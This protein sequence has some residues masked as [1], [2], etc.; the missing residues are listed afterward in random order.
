MNV[1]AD[2]LVGCKLEPIEETAAADAAYERAMPSLRD[3]FEEHMAV[4]PNRSKRTNEL[5]HYEANRYLGDWLTRPLDA[6]TRRDVETRLN[7]ITADHG[8][9][10]ANR[11][12]SLVRSVYRRP[13]IDLWFAAG[14]KFHRKISTPAEVQPR[15]RT[16]LDPGHT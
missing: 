5:Y 6:I 9:S 15:W 4:N 16:G 11:A 7:S 2:A 3:A 12:I 1:G 8:W 13:C 10:P 14:G